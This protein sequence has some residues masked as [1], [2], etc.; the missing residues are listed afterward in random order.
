MP[1]HNPSFKGLVF[2][3]D[4]IVYDGLRRKKKHWIGLDKERLW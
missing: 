1:D 2:Y 3:V 4:E